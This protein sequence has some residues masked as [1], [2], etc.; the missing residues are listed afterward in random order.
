MNSV[1][2]NFIML[3]NEIK[4]YVRIGE[5]DLKN[6][7]YPYMG[8][9]IKLPYVINEVLVIQTSAYGRGL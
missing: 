6:L 2:Y 5:R 1:K 7:T 3:K 8:E 9:G 4:S